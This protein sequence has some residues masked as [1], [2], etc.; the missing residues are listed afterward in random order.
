[1][2][3]CGTHSCAASLE[4]PSSRWAAGS[5]VG[6]QQATP[7]SGSRP[8]ATGSSPRRCSSSQ[9][10]LPGYSCWRL[11][12]TAALLWVTTTSPRG[13]D[14]ASASTKAKVPVVKWGQKSD[15]LYL[16]IPLTDVVDPDI[17]LA[18]RQVTLKATSKGQP[19]EAKLKFLREID[20]NESKYEVNKWNIQFDL[21]K[22]RKEPCWKR[23]LKS[24]ETFV[25]VKKDPDR[26][27][28]EDCQHAKELWR[29]AYFTAKLDGRDPSQGRSGAEEDASKAAGKPP[30]EK[31]KEQ[32]EWDKMI[33]DFRKR[34]VPRKSAA[35]QSKR[36]QARR[37]RGESKAEL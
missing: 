28:P 35:S 8:A 16:T 25:W 7:S 2:G 21:K 12:T 6:R 24:K 14:A 34:A 23:L 1:M 30:P 19:Y 9:S 10:L 11:A 27:Y 22:A 15:K 20:A 13:A 29:S 37:R 5:A 33:K 36:R 4:V 32:A 17:A 26:M 31:E 3:L 18:D